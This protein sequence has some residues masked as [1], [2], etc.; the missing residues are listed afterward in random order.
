MRSIRESVHSY[1]NLE[2]RR[3]L[4]SKR[5]ELK[6]SQRDLAAQLRVNHSFV[7]KIETGDRRLDLLELIE[8]IKPLNINLADFIEVHKS[9]I[10]HQ[11]DHSIFDIEQQNQL[12]L[13]T[14]EKLF[15]LCDLCTNFDFKTPDY[16][17]VHSVAFEIMNIA[18]NETYINKPKKTIDMSMVLWNT[19]HLLAN[20]YLLHFIEHVPVNIR[21]NGPNIVKEIDMS[22]K[23]IADPAISSDKIEKY[24]AINIEEYDRATHELY[25]KY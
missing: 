9:R 17:P 11:P 15:N 20:P 4:I 1:N 25:S 16:G 23:Q 19:I 22:I 7:G 14:R 12:F 18:K 13:S 21:K 3:K 10:D 8:Y 6:L 5:K 2:I 24:F